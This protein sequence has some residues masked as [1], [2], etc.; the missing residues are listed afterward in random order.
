MLVSSSPA[1]G[2]LSDI[3]ILDLT[4]MMAGPFGTMMLADHGAEVIKVESP[5][6]D[7]TRHGGPFHDDDTQK[8]HGGYFQ[9]VNRNKKSICLDLKTEAGKAALRHLV[10]SADAIIENFR[11]GVMDRLGLSYE[12]LIEINP[13]L[14]YGTLRGFGDRRTGAS[15]YADWPAFDVV[16][17]AMGGIMGVT[18]PDAETPTKVGPGVGDIMPGMMLAFGVLSAIHNA[19]RTGEGQFVDVSMVDSVFA[20]CERMVYQYSIQ[21]KVSGPEGN[22]HPFISPFGMF[23]AADGHITIA[24]QQDAF[25]ETLCKELS[26][27]HVLA[28]ERFETVLKRG[29]NKLELIAVIEELTSKFTKNELMEKLGGKIPY[30]PVFNIADIVSDPHFKARE[31]L[32]DLDQPGSDATTCVAGVPIKMSA[33]PGKVVRRGPYLGEDTETVLQEAGYSQVE[34]DALCATAPLQEKK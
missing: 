10:K 17:Q 28:D 9:S 20:V 7:M 2:S 33:T 4:Q 11:H 3:R 12:D 5:M 16:A 21:K 15:P 25:F 31:M 24:A 6:G 26:A 22:H 30:G 29:E 8:T 19:R 18:G 27:E 32:V 34:I 23:K 1:F 13:K 14:V